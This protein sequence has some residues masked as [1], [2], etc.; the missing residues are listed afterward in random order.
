[1][2]NNIEYT[3][4]CT[5]GNLNRAISVLSREERAEVF[6]LK[7]DDYIIYTGKY[8]YVVALHSG[9]DAVVLQTN[10]FS[11]AKLFGIAEPVHMRVHVQSLETARLIVD[12][13]S[14]SR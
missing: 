14:T 1:M 4:V 8:G 12:N 2:E 9:Y 11:L 3:R 6:I 10:D 5:F 13:G 7:H